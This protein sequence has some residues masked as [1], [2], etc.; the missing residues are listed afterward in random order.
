MIEAPPCGTVQG[1]V[2][3]GLLFSINCNETAALNKI[4]NQPWLYKEATNKDLVIFEVK[5]NDVRCVDDAAYTLGAQTIQDIQ[6]NI[7]I[8]CCFS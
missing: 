6:A 3:N 2:L 8:F 5:A 7:K 1:G 4:M